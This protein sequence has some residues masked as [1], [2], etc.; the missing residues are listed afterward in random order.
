MFNFPANLGEFFPEWEPGE[1]Y[2]VYGAWL[3]VNGF[4]HLPKTIYYT[5]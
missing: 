4:S 3:M 1:W 2:M 5:P